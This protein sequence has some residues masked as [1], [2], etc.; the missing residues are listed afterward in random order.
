M[1]PWLK[2]QC[3]VFRKGSSGYEFLVLKRLPEHGGFWQPITAS[4]EPDELLI[5]A[6]YR[7]LEEETSV[8][9]KDIKRVIGDIHY[10][11]FPW[12]E[13]HIA[14]E[15]VFGVEVKPETKVDIKS[16]VYDEHEDFRWVSFDEAL[17]LI[18]WDS[19]KE[20]LRELVKGI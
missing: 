9:K 2:I 14:K 19:N 17:K 3:I 8:S 16:N 7:E 15:H 6:V 1:K 13:E 12:D 11:E 4:V 10:F 5:D 18:K 20:A